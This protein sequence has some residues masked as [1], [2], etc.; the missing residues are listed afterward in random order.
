LLDVVVARNKLVM[1]PEVEFG[2]LL[3]GAKPV[4]ERPVFSRFSRIRQFATMRDS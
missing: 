3:D 1:P 4:I 2:Q